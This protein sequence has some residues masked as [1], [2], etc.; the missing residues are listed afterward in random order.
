MK[1]LIELNVNGLNYEVAVYP[2]D[3]L[4]DVLRKRLGFT[5]TK[6]GCGEG[7]CGTCTVLIDG[8]RALSCLTMAMSCRG[9]QILT[10]EGMEKKGELHPIQ[11]AFVAKGAIQCG[12]C[13]PGMVMSA[14]ALL[15]ENP[16]PTLDEIKYGMAGNL[17]RCTGYVKIVDAIVS[18]AL[19][20]NRQN[21]GEKGKDNA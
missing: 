7:S 6:K 9:K 20:L 2:Q 4:V 5:G 14:K 21:D 1:Q 16:T 15:D 17:C 19:E 13:T 18:A 10:I 3:L 11:K 12:F 8:K